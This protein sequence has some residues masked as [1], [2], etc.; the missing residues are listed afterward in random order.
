MEYR[1]RPHAPE[2][3]LPLGILTPGNISFHLK[4]RLEVGQNCFPW[5]FTAQLRQSDIFKKNLTTKG[6]QKENNSSD[7][8]SDF[9]EHEFLILRQPHAG[10][11]N[12]VRIWIVVQHIFIPYPFPLCVEY[13][14]VLL[15][16]ALDFLWPLKC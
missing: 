14:P 15:M 4:L 6:E 3:H 9:P 11:Q 8:N 13:I 2:S 1:L 7:T 16:L 5:F 10:L 12:G